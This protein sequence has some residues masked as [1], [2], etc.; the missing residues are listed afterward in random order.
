MS[1]GHN[2]HLRSML[3]RDAVSNSSAMQSTVTG[4]VAKG[5]ATL[6]KFLA[7]LANE[8]NCVFAG[9]CSCESTMQFMNCVSAAC[10]SGKCNCLDD[11][12]YMYACS[13]MSQACPDAGL[14]CTY[15]QATCVP[16]GA[17]QPPREPFAPL[18]DAKMATEQEARLVKDEVKDIEDELKGKKKVDWHE[19][20]T[21]H[22]L[23]IRAIAFVIFF[24]PLLI[25]A[26][27]YNM[28]RKHQPYP[29]SHSF[30]QDEAASAT[31]RNGWKHGLFA[32]FGDIPLCLFSWCCIPLRWADTMDKANDRSG[33]KVNRK[34]FMSY[35]LAVVVY[36]LLVA[37][38]PLLAGFTSI[39]CL[40]LCVMMRQKLRKLYDIKFGSWTYLE[41]CCTYLWCSCCAIVQE[42]RHVE[43]DYAQATKGAYVDTK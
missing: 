34:M 4:E 41:D 7:E 13:N 11:N 8:C 9:V 32:C 20:A 23:T 42:A 35:W 36:I 43:A 25:C 26:I 17:P 21:I 15:G 28:V 3:Q 31:P 22:N 39:I 30:R 1:S 33:Q 19:W 10:S 14:Q 27:L 6:N 29:F 24:A 18:K 38:N 37:L 5:A 40:A 12:H 2:H 16:P